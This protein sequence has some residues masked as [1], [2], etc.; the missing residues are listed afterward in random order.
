[1]SPYR[2]LS[3]GAALFLSQ[4]GTMVTMA[5]LQVLCGAP[6]LPG[7]TCMVPQL[8]SPGISHVCP[9]NS[10]VA[11]AKSLVYQKLSP[12]TTCGLAEVEGMKF[13]SGSLYRAVEGDPMGL[14]LGGEVVIC[15]E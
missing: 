13:Q 4:W 9:W 7:E 5:G 10:S 11:A 14:T 3:V 12:P 6:G 8:G 1:M 2:L 15:F